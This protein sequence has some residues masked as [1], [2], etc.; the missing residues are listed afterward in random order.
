MKKTIIILAVLIV[1]VI[2]IYLMT[3]NNKPRVDQI[4][5]PTTQTSDTTSDIVINIKNL[6][7][8]PQVLKVKAGTKVTWVNNDS[9]AH[10]VTSDSDNI[11]NSP[12]L[13]SGQSFS[14]TF[15]NTGTTNY[16]C[17]IHKTM[18]GIVIVE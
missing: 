5:V 1:V 8:N 6:A 14:F 4:S 12:T 9:M 10:T 13:S 11:L 16:H 7:F 18:Q 3:S 15:T 2:G 17:N